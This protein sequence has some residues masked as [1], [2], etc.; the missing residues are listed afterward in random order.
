VFGRHDCE[1]TVKKIT[2]PGPPKAATA[3]T[4]LKRVAAGGWMHMLPTFVL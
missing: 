4:T 3:D 1:T 2:N